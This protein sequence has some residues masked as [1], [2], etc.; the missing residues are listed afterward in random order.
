MGA[1]GH[2]LVA[3]F[4]LARHAHLPP[5]RAGGEDEGAAFERRA[6]FQH[7]LM[8]AAFGAGGDQLRRLLQ[9][10]DLDVIILHMG[11]ERGSELWPFGTRHG[12]EIFDV[13]RIEHLAPEAF[14]GNAGADALARGIDGRRGPGRP[15][16]DDQHLERILALD[17]FRRAG[18][19]AAVDF[20]NDLLQFHAARPKGFAVQEDGGDGHH[21]ALVHLRLEQRAVD[22]DV[23]DAGVEDAHQVQ[24]LHHVRAVLAG[25]GEIGFKGKVAVQP[26]DLFDQILRGL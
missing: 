2:A 3:I 21:L 18:G 12:D 6:V 15:A 24:S 8:I 20:G 7:D 25:Q 26:L 10:H 4:V 14:G 9:V 13:H 19:R 22:G 11:F 17:L 5:A 16:A 23:A 1:I